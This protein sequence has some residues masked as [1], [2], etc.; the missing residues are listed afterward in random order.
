MNT[1]DVANGI[2]IRNLQPGGS[3]EHW[4]GD[5]RVLCDDGSLPQTS[6]IVSFGQAAWD[7]AEQWGHSLDTCYMMRAAMEKAGFI[8]IH[9]KVD[10]LPIGPWPQD[11]TLEEAGRL[12]FHQWTTGLEGWAMYLLTKHGYPQPWSKEE[13]HVLV[14]KVRAEMQD[15]RIH[16]YQYV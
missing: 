1:A 2:R 9:E 6:N 14:A 12:H 13:V 10:K 11:R 15:S 4:D 16:A 8:D 3:I 5:P 7:A